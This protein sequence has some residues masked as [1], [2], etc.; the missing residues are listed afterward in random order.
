MK[1]LVHV[2]LTI[3]LGVALVFSLGYLHQAHVKIEALETKVNKD[4]K[5]A[6]LIK[7]TEKVALI[8]NSDS[9][10]EADM[11]VLRKTLSSALY[12]EVVNANSKETNHEA[13]M[14]RSP[15]V[16][17]VFYQKKDKNKVIITAIVDLKFKDVDFESIQTLQTKFTFGKEKN[18]WRI[19]AMQ[20]ELKEV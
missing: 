17:D 10:S 19:T 14:P 15:V 6:D 16:Q 1:Q 11:E 13:S 12:D 2:F 5:D 4:K 20:S 7:V 9:I 8:L 18:S 3:C